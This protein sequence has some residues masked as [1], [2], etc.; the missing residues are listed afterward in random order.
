MR[1]ASATV[2]TIVAVLLVWFG[3]PAVAA[4]SGKGLLT[5]EPD[6][7]MLDH[8]NTVTG[9]AFF[10]DSARVASASFDKS[11][12]IWN[13]LEGRVLRTLEGHAN[14]AHCVAVAPAGTY[15]ASGGGDMAVRVW[16][17]QTG[18]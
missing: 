7:V 2:L 5:I 18:D 12:K 10:P 4:V 13:V 11:V 6:R 14:G 17:P 9:L 3:C 1:Q 16:D 8:T 15:V